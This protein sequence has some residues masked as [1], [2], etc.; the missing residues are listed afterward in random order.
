M[1]S[2]VKHPHSKILMKEDLMISIGTK[3]ILLLICFF[4][5]E[6][7]REDDMTLKRKPKA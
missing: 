1:P 7:K 3:Q 2:N 5:V 4:K 6:F